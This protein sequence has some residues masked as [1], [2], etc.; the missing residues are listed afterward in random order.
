M[1]SAWVMAFAGAVAAWVPALAAPAA[2]VQL[3]QARS[4]NTSASAKAFGPPAP[5]T[6][7]DHDSSD[8]LGAFDRSVTSS[9]SSSGRPPDPPFLSSASGSATARQ[10]VQLAPTSISG[11]FVGDAQ[12]R[13]LVAS[14]GGTATSSWST[15]FRVDRPTP[16]DLDGELS[17]RNSA[18]SGAFTSATNSASLRFTRRADAGDAEETL[19]SFVLDVVPMPGGAG[20]RPVDLSG[21]LEPGYVYSLAGSAAATRDSSAPVVVQAFGQTT[22]QVTFTLTGVP[23]PAAAG[24]LALAAAVGLRRKRA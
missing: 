14:S 9:A 20:S 19:Y 17:V 10:S 18:A 6:D 13:S 2:A 21:V 1:R 5:S 23:E 16:F 3:T 8:A 4:L 7:A 12:A 22:A 24:V 15:T 11:S